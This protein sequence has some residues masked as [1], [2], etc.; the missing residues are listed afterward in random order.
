MGSEMCI[1]DRCYDKDEHKSGSDCEKC[2]PSMIATDFMM[3]PGYEMTV[4]GECHK[5][6]WAEEAAAAG[7]R[8]PC[9]QNSRSRRS[10]NLAQLEKAK[11]P[12]RSVP[13]SSSQPSGPRWT[14]TTSSE[15]DA[16]LRVGS[17]RPN[18]F[19]GFS[20]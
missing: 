15:H 6:T 12:R 10:R 7:W 3:V 4:D 13:C 9:A 1:R 16:R 2:D 20:G 8:E 18:D 14:T 19:P 5:K 11:L 17:H